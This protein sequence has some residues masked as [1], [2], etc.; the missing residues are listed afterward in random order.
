MLKKKELPSQLQ[1]TYTI[2]PNKMIQI[3]CG[4]KYEQLKLCQHSFA[5]F[6]DLRPVPNWKKH[7]YN[8]HWQGG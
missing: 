6:F 8:F 3:N 2:F 7:P 1:Q 5:D 4:A